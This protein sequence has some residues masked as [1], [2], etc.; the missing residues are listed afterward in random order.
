MRY[1]LS[2]TLGSNAGSASSVLDM[3]RNAH[4]AGTWKA[5]FRVSRVMKLADD[6]LRL[7]S[8]EVAGFHARALRAIGQDLADLF[9][10]KLD[11]ER[12]GEDFIVQGQCARSRLEA[13]A[14]HSGWTNLREFLN[15]DVTSL[16]AEN[17][18]PSVTFDR[19]YTPDDIFRLDEGGIRHRTGI[20]KIPDIRSLGE[21]LRTVGRLIDGENARLIRVLKDQRRISFEYEKNDGTKCSQEMTGME[22]YKL[23]RQYYDLRGKKTMVDL[24]NG[25]I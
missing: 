17:K 1:N 14:P 24:W 6:F 18:T 20:A 5:S 22:L 13:K 19:T 12:R 3:L 16:T 4:G 10:E 2:V 11:I 7:E 23:Q 9:P 21:I 15:R 25:R 8:T